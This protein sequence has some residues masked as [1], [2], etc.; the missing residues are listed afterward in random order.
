MCGAKWHMYCSLWTS[1]LKWAELI[2]AGTEGG[3]NM[4]GKKYA[5]EFWREMALN[6]LKP[7]R[8]T[9]TAPSEKAAIREIIREKEVIIKV[10]C[11]YCGK[12]YDETLEK[13][14]NCGGVY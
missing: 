3:A 14:P 5:P 11:S 10:R 12:P 9:D 1:D 13:C 6:N 8:K 7:K 2:K 4:L